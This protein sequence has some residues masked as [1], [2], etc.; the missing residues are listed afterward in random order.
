[1]RR[2]SG[3]CVRLPR[4]HSKAASRRRN[5]EY[6]RVPFALPYLCSFWSEKGRRL[7]GSAGAWSANQTRSGHCSRTWRLLDV[8]AHFPSD[9]VGRDDAPGSEVTEM[10]QGCLKK[11]RGKGCSMLGL[12]QFRKVGDVSQAPAQ[13]Q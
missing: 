10:V 1:M 12:F 7:I 11:K 4:Q 9:L 8:L 6:A 2:T 3:S 13:P 5:D